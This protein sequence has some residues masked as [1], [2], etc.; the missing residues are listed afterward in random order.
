[1][2]IIVITAEIVF[3]YETRTPFNINTASKYYLIPKFHIRI[4]IQS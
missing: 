4:F 2:T 3:T 1:M